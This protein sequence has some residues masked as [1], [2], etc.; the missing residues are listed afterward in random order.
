MLDRPV[1][2]GGPVGYCW[3]DDSTRNEAERVQTYA[4]VH[5][6]S[7]DLP[8][9]WFLNE[10]LLL[11]RDLARLRATI[12]QHKSCSSCSTRSTTSPSSLDLK[13]REA[14]RFSPR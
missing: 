9:R 11:P 2:A 3:Q 10:G 1:I 12:E 5:E 7:R 13:D 14:G 4:R 6:T 8:L